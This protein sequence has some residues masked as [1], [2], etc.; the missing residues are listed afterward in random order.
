MTTE[1]IPVAVQPADPPPSFVAGR[2]AA[3]EALNTMLPGLA[4]TNIPVL[5]V[6]E[7]GSGKD[8]YAQRLHHLSL[9]PSGLL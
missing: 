1:T 8:V 3:I 2:S 7:S 9:R 5:I 4:Q 6:G